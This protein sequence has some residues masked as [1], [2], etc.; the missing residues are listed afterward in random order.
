MLR[1]VP[2]PAA[3]AESST[4]VADAERARDR[5]LV[6]RAQQ[7]D[8]KA[9]GELLR[10]HG[11]TLYRTVLLPRLGNAA[12]AEDA[13]S[14]TYGK[15]LKGLGAFSWSD[16]IG[17]YPWFRTVGLRVVLD[18]FRRRK[19]QVVWSEEDV[20][21]ELD[22]SQQGELALDDAAA[23][24]QDAEAVRKKLQ[25]A[26]DSINPRYAEAIRLRVL[27]EQP[28]EQVAEQLG[29]SVATFDVLLHRALSSLKKKLSP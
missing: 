24:K 27:A 18:Q 16:D 8:R 28:R 14:E 21:H 13:L 23:Q 19:R 17:F 26:L 20:V 22:R 4:H 5:E 7:G 10:T 15:V 11:P 12:A 2:P 6:A 29:V 25:D 1:L 9:L 3:D